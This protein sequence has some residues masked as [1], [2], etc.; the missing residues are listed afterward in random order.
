PSGE[1]RLA[2]IPTIAPYLLPLFLGPFAAR[3]PGV[4]LQVE[5]LT[6]QNILDALE[7]DSIDAGILATPLEEENFVKQPL[8]YE[9]FCV[10][11]HETHPLAKLQ[12]INED[13]LEAKDIWLLSEGHCLRNQ[14]VR[15]C[16]LKG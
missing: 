4:K 2:L 14:I 6:T 8:Y 11:A 3:Y 15:I 10:L 16:S 1:F 9:P 12:Q 7:R 5:E 13:K